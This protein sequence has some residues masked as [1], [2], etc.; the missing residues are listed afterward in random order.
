[1]A[2]A[3]EDPKAEVRIEPVKVT[4]E[5]IAELSKDP[6]KL[7]EYKP[8]DRDR[9]ARVASGNREADPS[10]VVPDAGLAKETVQKPAPEPG[11]QEDGFYRKNKRDAKYWTDRVNTLQ[12][13][14]SAEE[15][16]IAALAAKRKEIEEAKIETPADFIADDKSVYETN[17]KLARR[18]EVLETYIKENGTSRVKELTEDLTSATEKATFKSFEE[19]QEK[20]PSLKTSKPVHVL[21][22]EWGS[23]LDFV[24]DA[25]G[26]KEKKK[27]APLEELR[28]EAYTRWVEDEDF[29]K[30]VKQKPPEEIEKLQVLLRANARVQS[31][32]GTLKGNLLDLMDDEEV[33]PKIFQRGQA[34]A[35]KEATA[36]TLA[37]V[38]TTKE[39]KTISPSD[40]AAKPAANG[41]VLTR[42]EAVATLQNLI[43]KRK[44]GLPFT[45]ED[46][47]LNLRC[48]RILTRA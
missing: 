40:G 3:T 12:Q 30:Q 2:T 33:L 11:T 48:Q 46:R 47:E 39:L 5:L 7:R 34:D 15:K 16:R 9:I 13:T 17:Q 19:M 18:L 6:Q 41:G 42:E 29:Q 35:A 32:G 26:L 1:M 38:S 24:V 20:F 4:K 36:K 31:N 45:A 22:R 28:Q 44:S 8:A 37:A 23:F 14:A 27:D 10:E 21:N 43:Q 25:S